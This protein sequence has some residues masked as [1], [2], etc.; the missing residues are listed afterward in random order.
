MSRLARLL[1]LAGVLPLAGC[2]L[3]DDRPA[4]LSRGHDDHFAD[5]FRERYAP[6]PVVMPAGGGCAPCAG[7]GAGGGYSFT[8][9]GLM[10]GS[11]VPGGGFAAP[12]VYTPPG[13]P[14]GLPAYPSGEGVPLRTR[15]DNELPLP[16]EWSKPSGAETSRPLAPRPPA[17]LPAGR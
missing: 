14:G 1:L 2:R 16:L 8:T 3:F 7:G 10:S 6:A 12:A 9:G 4:L 17:T 15:P 13:V 11:P 5:R